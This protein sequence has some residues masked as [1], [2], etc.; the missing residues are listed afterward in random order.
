MI[1]DLAMFKSRYAAVNRSQLAVALMAVS[2]TPQWVRAGDWR[3]V[4]EVATVKSHVVPAL[5][6]SYPRLKA[7]ATTTICEADGPG[8][9]TMLHV[10]ALGTN[11]GMG[12]DSRPARQA[13][14]RVF[15]NGEEKP[16]IDMPLM[17]FLGDIDCDSGYFQTVYFAKVRESHNFRLPLPFE[18]SI[19]IEFENPS[20]QDL[21]GYADVQWDSVSRLPANCGHLHAQLREGEINPAAPE[22]VFA[23][24]EPAKIVAHWLQYQSEKSEHGEAI[25]EANQELYLD[26]DKTPTINYLG[27]EDV[28]GYSWG[29][30]GTNGNNFQAILKEDD[31]S[32]GSR[33]AVL[34]CRESDAI[35]FQ[36]SAK[37]VITYLHDPEAMKRL[38][39]TPVQYRQCV[40]YYSEK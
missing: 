21:V 15:Y 14:I 38:D 22:V 39:G 6:E 12:F 30:K 27:T 17:D 24:E 34:R 28:Y 20:D 37:W 18:R 13:R 35:S 25:C 26:G 31:L 40:Y 5:W 7:G 23:L 1:R 8:V 16:A 33:I 36:S 4:A 10:S 2:F 3:S 19:R 11:F 32:P 29:F 9:V